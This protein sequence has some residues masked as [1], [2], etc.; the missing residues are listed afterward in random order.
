MATHKSSKTKIHYTVSIEE[1]FQH[2]YDVE[3]T[4]KIPQKT[5]LLHLPTWTP[6]SYT[7]RDYSSHLFGFGAHFQTGKKAEWKQVDLSSWEVETKGKECTVYYRVYAFENTVRTNYLDSEFGFI[8]PPGLF[9]FPDGFLDAPIQVQF[10]LNNYFKKIYTPLTKR[11]E[12][13]Y[14]SNFDELYDSPFLLSNVKS[15]SFQVESCR[16]EV[17]ILGDISEKNRTKLL[18]D[19]QLITKYQI[20]TMKSSPNVYYL[21]IINLLE[22]AYGGLEH[23]ACSVN[24]FDGSLVDN[25]VEYKKLLGLLSHEYFHLWNVKRIRPFALGPFDYQR[26]ALTKEL[27]IAEGITSFY[28]NY[29]L[30]KTGQFSRR[31]YLQEIVNDYSRMESSRGDLVM[32]L[33]ESSFTAWTKYYKQNQNSHNISISYYI[34]GALLA[35][36]INLYILEKTNAEKQLLDVMQ[37]LYKTYAVKKDRGFNKKEFFDAIEESTGVDAFKEFNSYLIEKKSIPVNHYLKKIGVKIEEST[38]KSCLHFETKTQ[39]GKEIVSKIF[40]QWLPNIDLSIGDEILAINNLRCE[41]EVIDKLATEIESGEVIDVLISRRGKI[42]K[43]NFIA[44]YSYHFRFEIDEE[45]IKSNPLAQKF[46]ET[47]PK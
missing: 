11:E 20:Q 1:P 37:Y 41:K 4:F 21:F 5:A 40:Y 43:I 22:K 9:L 46:F 13:L 14:A 30:Y 29:F 38:K 16:H 8:N 25:F 28:D 17:V 27:W 2:Y 6:G 18:E 3:L 39:K 47:Y 31:D 26:P 33:E 35:L 7:I 45:A 23:K 24:I 15:N 44:N 42:R 32:T 36:C 34:K 12:H 19:I 10:R